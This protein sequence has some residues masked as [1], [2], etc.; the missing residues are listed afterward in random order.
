MNKTRERP[1]PYLPCNGC[2]L[3]CQEEICMV[4]QDVFEIWFKDTPCPAL[5]SIN[6]KYRCALVMIEAAAPVE[7]KLAEALGIGRGCCADYQ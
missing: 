4:G 3:C 7:K 6:G 2:G 1:G 5:T